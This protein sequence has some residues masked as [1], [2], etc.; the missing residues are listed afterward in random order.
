MSTAAEAERRVQDKFDIYAYNF[1]RCCA[2]KFYILDKKRQFVKFRPNNVQR[3]LL[4]WMLKQY[5]DGV[6]VRAIIL[7][8]RQMGVSTARDRRPARRAPRQ[9]PGCP[10]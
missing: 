4:V 6:P 2:E 10:C 7:K 1:F 8:A 3:Q 9:L 5:I